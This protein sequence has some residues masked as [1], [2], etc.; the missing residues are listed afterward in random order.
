MVQICRCLVNRAVCRAVS[1]CH[2][3]FNPYTFLSSC[4]SF[5]FLFVAI[6]IFVV[7]SAERRHSYHV[8]FPSAFL[9][10]IEYS[11][12]LSFVCVCV[13]VHIIEDIRTKFYTIFRM[14]GYALC[15]LHYRTIEIKL[16]DSMVWMRL[17]ICCMLEHFLTIY[18]VVMFCN[19]NNI[20][21]NQVIAM[22]FSMTTK[23]L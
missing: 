3:P 21:S 6:T 4:S 10:A 14:L 11:F 13:S 18:C 23:T 5:Y 12:F 22:P 17:N 19:N 8:R 2:S 7:F 9:S 16:V 20:R 15:S 1:L